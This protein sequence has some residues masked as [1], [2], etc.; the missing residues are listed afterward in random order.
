MPLSEVQIANMALH[1]LK[2]KRQISALTDDTVEARAVN[3]F[4]ETA[5]D[6]ALSAADWSFARR[7]A[8]L[9]QDSAAPPSEWGY[10]YLLP[11]DFLVARFIEDGVKVRHHANEIKFRVERPTDSLVLYTDAASAVLVYTAQYKPVAYWTSSF[12]SLM[13]R[14]LASEMASGL[15]DT[16]RKRVAFDEYRFARAEAA[17]LDSEQEVQGE[18]DPP[19]IAARR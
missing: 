11:D 1:H 4:W 6:D 7:R 15:V 17:R 13:A 3:L 9:A 2:V 18:P 10:A 19:L 5:R 12:V 8:T 16:A 14:S